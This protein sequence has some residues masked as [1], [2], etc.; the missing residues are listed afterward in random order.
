VESGSI[1]VSIATDESSG[2][3]E[4]ETTESY[5]SN[6]FQIWDDPGDAN[7]VIYVFIGTDFQLDIKLTST[8]KILDAAL[9]FKGNPV[10]LIIEK[11]KS[12]IIVKS[13]LGTWIND[14]EDA[15]GNW[16]FIIYANELK[17]AYAGTGSGEMFGTVDGNT[18]NIEAS[19]GQNFNAAGSLSGDNANGAFSIL[20]VVMAHGWAKWCLMLVGSNPV[21]IDQV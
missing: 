12:D 4:I 19:D 21:M 9:E 10:T 7:N 11:T 20:I 15:S 14:S 13:Y 16:N 5:D 18:L 17:G 8:G 3:C 6:T 2:S 1:T